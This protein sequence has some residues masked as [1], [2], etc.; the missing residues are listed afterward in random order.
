MKRT[1]KANEK[2]AEPVEERGPAKGSASRPTGPRTQSR[3][4][5]PSAGLEGVRAAASRDKDLRLTALL[6]HVDVSLLGTCYQALAPGAAPGVDNVTW[7]DYGTDLQA[8]LTDLHGRVH[9]GAYRAKPSKRVRIP[10]PDGRQRPLGIAS[11]EDKIVQKAVAKVL[12]QIYEVDFLGFSY[13]FRPGRSQHD[14]L[15][16][17]YVGLWQQRINWV[18]DAD[19]RG[20]FD[21]ISHAWLMKFLEHRIGDPRVLRLIRKWLRA[22]VLEADRWSETTE[23]T[24]QGAVI[25]PLL[26]NVYLHYVFDLWAHHWRSHEANGDVIIVRYADDF[27][28]GFERRS[29]AERF[30]KEL[31]ERFVKFGLSLHPDKTRLLEFGRYA[32]ER[33]RRRGEGKPETFDFLG[34]T[35]YCGKTRKGDFSLKRKPMASRMRRKLQAVRADLRRRL[36]HSRNEVGAWL[37]SVLQG[38]MNYYAVPDTGENVERFRTELI[39]AWRWVLHRQ[40][41][42]GRRKWTWPRMRRLADFWLP[43]PRILH[44][45]P[46]QRLIVTTRGRS[47]MR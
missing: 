39:K 12:E 38:W 37:G 45:Y 30:L 23:G 1:N 27:V 40:S 31:R 24:P 4:E 47:R 6:H 41:Q 3:T 2:A 36:H 11:L 33:R 10:K 19:I 16:A 22:G 15:D 7:A 8:R 18:L 43:R 35:H 44:P 25:S 42:M 32:A 14:A 29:E 46:T 21:T 9:R 20:Y 17:L 13:G 5:G 26:A 28:V 34:F